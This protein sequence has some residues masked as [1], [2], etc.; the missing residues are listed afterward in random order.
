MVVAHFLNCQLFQKMKQFDF[1]LF[2]R[3]KSADRFFTV[4]FSEGR[5]PLSAAPFVKVWGAIINRG[6][7]LL[8]QTLS[9][10]QAFTRQSATANPHRHENKNRKRWSTTGTEQTPPQQLTGQRHVVPNSYTTNTSQHNPAQHAAAPN[11]CPDLSLTG[12]KA[13]TLTS[14]S[15]NITAKQA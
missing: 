5:Y 14:A 11:P 12:S 10:S 8:Y 3:N 2:F 6:F 1:H 4:R 7:R 15:H 13:Q 9:H